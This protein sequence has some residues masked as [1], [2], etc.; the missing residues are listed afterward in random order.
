MVRLRAASSSPHAV[1]RPYYALHASARNKEL[2]PHSD[3]HQL[4]WW[5]CSFA[6]YRWKDIDSGISN[7]IADERTD[8]R[9]AVG[10]FLPILENIGHLQKEDRDWGGLS[11]AAFYEARASGRLFNLLRKEDACG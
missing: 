1:G 11:M 4:R 10:I 7:Q 2:C 6:F 8:V 5:L 9:K 3:N